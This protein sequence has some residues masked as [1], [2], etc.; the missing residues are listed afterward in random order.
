[1]NFIYAFLAIAI[2]LFSI[3]VALLFSNL[4][5]V[6]AFIWLFEATICYF[7]AIKLNS[8]KV[9]IAS[10]ILFAVGLLKLFQVVVIGFNSL[11][12]G[13]LIGLIFV[14]ISLFLN[15]FLIRKI[16]NPA[17]MLRLT[18]IRVMHII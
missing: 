7:F 9:F 6:I 3:S 14:C 13:D 17:V 11:D 1:L 2:S 8:K 18:L 16:D 10:N 12:Y 5:I 4:P 15:V